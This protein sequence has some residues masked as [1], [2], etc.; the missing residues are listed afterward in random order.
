MSATIIIEINGFY[1]RLISR[2]CEDMSDGGAW[3]QL[4]IH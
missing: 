2:I 3:C 1:G 4:Q